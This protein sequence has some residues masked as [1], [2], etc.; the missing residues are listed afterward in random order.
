MNPSHT[1]GPWHLA[2]AETSIPVKAGAK[3]VASV[4]IG[5]NDQADARLIA[6]APEMLEQLKA[7]LKIVD[8]HRRFVLTLP[9]AHYRF[10]CHI[11]AATGADNIRNAIAK[12]EGRTP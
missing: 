2:E 12:A 9:D 4:R 5:D 11:P 8:A 1:P 7:A 6:A 10:A 3:T